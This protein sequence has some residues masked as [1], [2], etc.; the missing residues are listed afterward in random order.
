LRYDNQDD[1]QDSAAFRAEV[2][3]W[4]DEHCPP[5]IRTPLD[6]GEALPSGGIQERAHLRP[7]TR[8]W[9]DTMAEQG[10]IVPQWEPKHGGAGLSEAQARII[11]EEL[12][13]LGARPPLAPL[14]TGIRMLAPV[15]LRDATDEQR[16]RFLPE[17]AAGRIRWC[18][19]YSEPSAGSD[20]AGLRTAAVADGDRYIVTG[21]KIWSSYAHHSDWIF[22]LVRTGPEKHAGISFL[23]I[24]LASPGIEVRP[25]SLLSGR[26][27]FCEV[28]LDQVPV[29]TAN[30][31]GRVGDG[32]RIAKELL[33]HERSMLGSAGGGLS[34]S[35]G[36]RLPSL[37]EVIRQFSDDADLAESAVLTDRLGHHLVRLRAL[38]ATTRRY[39]DEPAARAGRASLLKLVST[40]LNME[41]QDLI[42]DASGL[43]ALSWDGLG[44]DERSASQARAWLRSR[45]NSIEGGTSEI[46]LN[47]I[48]KAELNLSGRTS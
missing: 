24:D 37:T 25:I 7:D 44:S 1:D 38:Q 11:T 23:L 35:S 18:Q 31:I 39:R 20:L 3:T 47:I 8:L 28:F 14:N 22:C 6:R 27:D 19:G 17:I 29:P 34:G 42:S 13:A 15:L 43:A 32:W 12:R 9:L 5:T 2:R 10:W 26:S 30:L 41:R 21:Q 4:L 45:A 48:A 46:Q 33:G 40:E 16:D 36:A